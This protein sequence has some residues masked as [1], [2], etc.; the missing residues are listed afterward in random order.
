[1]LLA[2][3]G[4]ILVAAIALV[5]VALAQGP[6]SGYGPGYGHGST[7]NG[8]FGRGYN[9]GAN[10][11]VGL[12]YRMGP[13]N[14]SGPRFGLGPRWGGPD[15]SMVAVAAEQLGMTRAELIAE[16]QS[17]KTIVQVAEEHSVALDTIVD[18]FVASRAERLTDLVDSG[19]LTQVQADAMLATM[20]ANVTEHLNEAWSPRGPGQG[21]GPGF[22]DEDGDGVCDHAGTG[23]GLGQGHGP[24]F[25]D[26]DGDGVCDHAGNGGQFGRRGGRMM[27][28]WAQ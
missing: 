22:V 12:G 15:N 1:M 27:G 20:R 19:Q 4:A 28:R 26:E 11:A 21:H 9:M 24:G 14:V 3:I 18:A 10:N 8:T 5:P 6:A 7:L 23:P 25:V 2:G 16:L 17:G 13:G